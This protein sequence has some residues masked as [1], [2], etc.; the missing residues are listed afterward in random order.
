M[1]IDIAFSVL[2]SF[3][4][5]K[6]IILTQRNRK[7]KSSWEDTYRDKMTFKTGNR[8]WV[9]NILQ[10]FRIQH[11]FRISGMFSVR[12]IVYISL[13]FNSPFYNHPLFRIL[14]V[15]DQDQEITESIHHSYS[16]GIH[17]WEY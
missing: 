3:Y 9:T 10:T 13:A 8:K 4:V 2:K 15:Y 5:L 6:C 7:V 11:N 16:H 14:M 1:K 12:P 17:S